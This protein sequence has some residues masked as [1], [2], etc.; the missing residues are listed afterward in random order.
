MKHGADT[1]R[2]VTYDLG[3]DFLIQRIERCRIF[4]DV[5]SEL[6]TPSN[7]AKF[8]F[9]G[10]ELRPCDE[11][12]IVR[13]QADFSNA[14]AL[15]GNRAP[16]FAAIL[17]IVSRYGGFTARIAVGDHDYAKIRVCGMSGA[18]H[19]CD[20]SNLR[21]FPSWQRKSVREAEGNKNVLVFALALAPVH[22]VHTAVAVYRFAAFSA[23]RES[24]L[25]IWSE[26]GYHLF[27]GVDIQGKHR[28]VGVS[29]QAV[30]RKKER[31]FRNSVPA[32]LPVGS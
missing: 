11:V 22:K 30:S 27:A 6:V 19:P 8:C 9:D 15:H 24:E 4:R 31:I 1:D 2:S 21:R 10:R 18:G 5:H 14:P 26:F 28:A 29:D 7:I 32:R 23:V 13:S 25:L 17:H 3:C 16:Q 20:I 12:D